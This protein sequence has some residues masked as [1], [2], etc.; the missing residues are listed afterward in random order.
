MYLIV[1][2]YFI[3]FIFILFIY[4]LNDKLFELLDLKYACDPIIEGGNDII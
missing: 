2:I 3:L 1:F 4:L